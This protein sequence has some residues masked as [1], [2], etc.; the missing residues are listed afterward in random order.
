MKRLLIVG[1][2]G[3]KNFGDDAMLAVLVHHLRRHFSLTVFSVL[4]RKLVEKE[5]GVIS[6]S[7][8]TPIRL[9]SE[10]RKADFVLVGGGSL[11]KNSSMVKLAPILLLTLLMR[12]ARVFFGVEVHRLNFI[13]RAIFAAVCRGAII[14]CTRTAMA[15]RSNRTALCRTMPDLAYG[16]CSIGKFAQRRL[17]V[18]QSIVGV[19]VRPSNLTDPFNSKFWLDQIANFLEELAPRKILFFPFQPCD[20]KE[21]RKLV[22]SLRV[23]RVRSRIGI[24]NAT[25][26]DQALVGMRGISLA[27]GMRLHFLIFASLLDVPFVAVPYHQKV[28]RFANSV[29]APVLSSSSNGL[30]VLGVEMIRDKSRQVV[31]MIRYL[32]SS[33]DSSAEARDSEASLP[34]PLVRR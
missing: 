2:Y 21:I 18:S 3:A 11:I 17:D 29:D 12:K 1:N 10:M 28:I 13:F 7:A 26:F 33:L 25:S 32:I 15:N 30:N 24:V 6:V 23:R 4:Y 5:F 14:I 31:D 9:L 27:I 16:L 34:V 19:N 20:R 8:L 22:R